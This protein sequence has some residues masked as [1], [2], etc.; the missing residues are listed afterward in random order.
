[1]AANRF[2][3]LENLCMRSCSSWSNRHACTHLSSRK[4]ASLLAKPEPFPAISPYLRAI[5]AA[6]CVCVFMACLKIKNTPSILF[7]CVWGK[8]SP[9]LPWFLYPAWISEQPCDP[10]A[11]LKIYDVSMFCCQSGIKNFTVYL[12]NW[13]TH[14]CEVPR[15]KW[16]AKL[17][18]KDKHRCLVALR[19]C[20][21]CLRPVVSPAQLEKAF[22]VCRT[23]DVLYNLQC[24]TSVP[25]KQIFIEIPCLNS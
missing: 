6:L 25:S 22:V 5:V 10:P 4:S 3:S 13:I 15:G 11:S 9:S 19:K 23:I 20:V 12:L 1:M 18:F 7:Y 21:F 14:C 2:A 8:M 16:Y 24:D 17:C